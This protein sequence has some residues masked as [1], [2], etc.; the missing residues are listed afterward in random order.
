M[1]R[2]LSISILIA[3]ALTASAQNVKNE[4]EIQQMCTQNFKAWTA[5]L[6]KTD[7][8]TS[9]GSRYSGFRTEKGN[10]GYRYYW[11]QDLCIMALEDAAEYMLEPRAI[12]LVD[13]VLQGFLQHYGGSFGNDWN[14]YIDDMGWNGSAFI[15]GYRITGRKEYLEGAK[16]LFAEN[17]YRGQH[18][19]GDCW[20]TSIQDGSAGLWW[21]VKPNVH[22][23]VGTW[24]D[25]Y[26]S[27]LGVS[28]TINIGMY[29]Y[30]L[31]GDS[32][33]IPKC[34]NLWKW[35]TEVLWVEG[36]GIAEGWRPTFHGIYNGE[37]RD[38]EEYIQSRRTTH[39][40]GTFFE[41]TVNLWRL[42]GKD[43]YYEWI[44]KILE[45]IFTKRLDNNYV[46]QNAFSAKDGSWC[47]EIARPLTMLANYANLWDATNTHPLLRK[48]PA[49][50]TYYQWMCNSGKTIK[51]D[52]N[53]IVVLP[54][55]KAGSNIE[56]ENAVWENAPEASKPIATKKRYPKCPELLVTNL[57]KGNMLHFVI[58]AEKAGTY[59]IGLTY[60]ASKRATTLISLNGKDPLRKSLSPYTNAVYY[61]GANATIPRSSVELDFELRK[62]F[63]II[64]YDCSTTAP[65]LDYLCYYITKTGTA[66]TIELAD[67]TI[68]EGEEAG[69]LYGT[70]R[71]GDPTCTANSMYSGY[72]L[73]QNLGNGNYAEYT[74]NAPEAGKYTMFINYVSE[75]EDMEI[76]PLLN[77]AEIDAI[78][79]PATHGEI[80][81]T[82]PVVIDLQEGSNTI[83]LAN[84]NAFIPS[85]D[86]IVLI[87]GDVSDGINAI[88]HDE[89]Q[90]AQ[91]IYDLSGRRTSTPTKG[92]YIIN[93]KKVVIK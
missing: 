6:L 51:D 58:N 78:P 12:Q 71:N 50:F 14:E 36:E 84:A 52:D 38:Q 85:I 48:L 91:S 93:G 13:D 72:G 31:T 33:Y 15:R 49:G 29:I 55:R 40:L 37:Q 26:K 77:K 45:N 27:P 75:E 89:T 59:H 1:K 61:T 30:E 5:A 73:L 18:G 9:S 70:R 3:V 28:P 57:G 86:N 16:K 65:D 68:I 53:H 10:D 21:R 25:V 8:T 44:G 39:D 60:E 81:K 80:G 47:W 32:T 4:T 74:F 66:S 87:K 19:P 64:T 82:L 20:D 92:V 67:T 76:R 24:N 90:E 83:R 23:E 54:T 41:A 35:E 56:A 34:E 63:N 7:F 2:F 62:G 88:T 69:K 43:I 17:W 46:I 79:V 42:T 22:A 11:E